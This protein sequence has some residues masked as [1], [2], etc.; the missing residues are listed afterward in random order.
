MSRYFGELAST[1]LLGSLSTYPRNTRPSFPAAADAPA[2]VL[3]TP[4]SHVHRDRDAGF[5]I[6]YGNSSGYGT[7]RHYVADWWPQRFRCM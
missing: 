7:D 3:P 5:G 2:S 6:G 4:I 1:A